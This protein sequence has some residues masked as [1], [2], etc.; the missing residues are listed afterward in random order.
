M[1]I[2]KSFFKFFL[3]VLPIGAFGQSTYLNQGTNDAMFIDRM[4]IKQQKNTDFNFSTLRPFNRKHIVSE[5]IFLDSARMGYKDS[6]GV[7]KY[8]EW[9][10]LDLTAVDEYNLNRL[11]MNNSEW[12]TT[13]KKS[14]WFTSIMFV[15]LL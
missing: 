11:M 15:L 10:D 12:V 6:T 7:D 4:E 9:T 5:A 13:P 1:Q 8:K 14:F 3:F 2:I